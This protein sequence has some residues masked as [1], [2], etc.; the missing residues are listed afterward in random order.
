M[1]LTDFASYDEVRSVLGV[2]ATELADTV[3]TQPQW[4][5]LATID[6][7]DVNL[8]IPAI[9]VTISALAS[10]IR[11]AQQQR[12][13]ELVRLFASYSCAKTLL[14]SLPLFS[15]RSLT[16]GRA[17]FTRHEDAHLDVRL[18]VQGMHERLR[19]KLTTVYTTLVPA[20]APYAD[21]TYTYSASVGLA[22]NPVTNA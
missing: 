18:G 20:D 7:E 14:S 6:L 8:G 19:I 5:T 10:N 3:L 13:Y 11:T 15:V 16:D 21:A 4:G 17:E 9:Y 2:S 22:I 1:L 12:F